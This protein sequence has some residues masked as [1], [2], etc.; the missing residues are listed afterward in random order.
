[1][2]QYIPNITIIGIHDNKINIFLLLVNKQVKNQC[3]IQ[4]QQNNK[5]IYGSFTFIFI[6]YLL[7]LTAKIPNE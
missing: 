4:I 1:M 7:K 5:M 6:Q 2:T 3:K